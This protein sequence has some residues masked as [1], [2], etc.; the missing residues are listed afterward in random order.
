ML[1]FGYLTTFPNTF[2]EDGIWYFK[3][4]IL[5]A[6]LNIIII[7]S[8]CVTLVTCGVTGVQ[9]NRLQ[10]SIITS[11][12]SSLAPSLSMTYCTP[13]DHLL[14]F[15]FCL[16]E[17]KR[18]KVEHYKHSESANLLQAPIFTLLTFLG[19]TG[20]LVPKS[21]HFFLDTPHRLRMFHQIPFITF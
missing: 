17:T 7:M 18:L 5:F 10:C 14:H 13:S 21:N 8:I 15:H 16:N 3:Y 20:Q 2:S 9:A 6:S 12:D 4:Q 1:M 11:F 19:I